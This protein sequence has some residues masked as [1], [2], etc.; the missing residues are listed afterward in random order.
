M[1]S[2]L[3]FVLATVLVVMSATVSAQVPTGVVSGRV[4]SAD[5]QPLP[6]VTVSASGA[7][8]QGVRTT[9]TSANGD[10]I[11][12]LLPPGQYT[13]TYEIGS[14]EPVKEQRNIAGTQNAVVDVTM[15]VASVREDVTVFGEA[16]VF[17]GNAHVATNFKQSLMATLP[18]NRTIDAVLLMAPSV[19]PTGPRAGYT[20]NGSQSYENLFTLNGAVVTENLRGQPF[21][22][23]IEDA[24]QETTVSTAGI[25]AEYGR[26]NGGV[27]NAITKSGG[28]TFS[29]SFRTS[30]AN[31][32]WRSFSPYEST[33]LIANPALK[34]KLDK[35]VPTYEFTIGGPVAKERLWFFAAARKQKQELARTTAGTNIAYTR[36]N[37]EKRYE[38]KLT[39]N[40]ARGHS[41]QGS[42]LA[43]DQVLENNTAQ[44]VMDLQSLTDQGQPQNLYAIHY[45][46]VLRSNLFVEAQYSGRNL[47]FTNTGASTTDRINGTVVLDIL[48]ARRFWSPTFCSGS[49][50][51]GGN[52][53]RNNTDF[54][55]KGSYFLSDRRT[56]SHH[57]VFG[58]DRFLD[59]MKQ[60]THASG[61]DYRI[62]GTSSIVRG[63]VV[64]P[65]F[66]ANT[67]IDYNPIAALSEGTHLRT[68][69]LFVNDDWRANGHF[70]F[71]VGLRI[72][73]ND[74]TDGGG[75]KTGGG[76]KLSPRLS[77]VW[78][79]K[80]DGNW[81]LSTGYARYVMALNP[82][83][84][85][86]ATK[87]GN[88]ATYRWAYGGPIINSDASAANLVSTADAL[89]TVFDWF[90]LAGGTSLRPFAA[91]S[92]PGV[93]MKIPTPLRS[94][95]SDEYSAGLSRTL[96][97]RGTA[98]VDYVF[99]NYSNFYQLR[100]DM[101]TGR[102]FDELG[103]P[104]DLNVVENTDAT[105]R[106]YWGIGGQAS[107]N[108]SEGLSVGGNYTLS[109]AYGNLEGETVNGG[110]SG[111]SIASYPEYKQMSWN[112]PDGDLLI[113]QRHRAR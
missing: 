92:L 74:A 8:L 49:V 20:I 86:S 95:F 59:L 96:G 81:A 3:T 62:R 72:D 94:P 35:T 55:V 13:L 25:S 65:Q 17:A 53:E 46:G 36:T 24:L 100:T 91:A 9:V 79:P 30:F 18:S 15:S 87:N 109:H 103:N 6:G 12:P 64:Y 10:Y 50:C 29:G 38:G 42:Y 82:N 73:T 33:Q 97:N 67:F 4:T 7:S 69:S 57:V 110:P 32:D 111:A 84:A 78:D 75:Q 11:I 80:G 113:D 48:N 104:F 40:L 23:Y 70:S 58:Y 71:N 88:A 31:D 19:H 102:V 1:R 77:A 54:V 37:D 61:S 89:K 52:E 14:F 98:R 83:L 34:P 108:F 16:Q 28:N 56:G 93:N 47:E 105:E 68:H 51:T 21:T 63:E 101:S 2:A 106:K 27:A 99:R 85:G 44:V 43:M 22:L 41:V 5:G 76:T 26:F 60:N 39:Y 107:Y 90:D 66:L 112:A 45:T